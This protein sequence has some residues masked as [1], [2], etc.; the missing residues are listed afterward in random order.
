[1]KPIS[2]SSPNSLIQ[3]ESDDSQLSLFEELELKELLAKRFAIIHT[4]VPHS[5][6]HFHVTNRK[7]PLG[8]PSL[9]MEKRMTP[10]SPLDQGDRDL[11]EF[12]LDNNYSYRS[13]ARRFNCCSDTLK[14]LLVRE[15]LAEFDGAKYALSPSQTNV[16]NWVR[17]CMSCKNADPR[18]RWQ[19]VCSA[20]KSH[21]A[22]GVPD[23]FLIN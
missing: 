14:R 11:L 7:P 20:C 12:M 17:P 6:I 5:S 10:R 8:G 18:P 9:A 3:T 15:N 19:Y 1:M 13:M 4:E 22:S 23:E 2:L 21:E 16:D